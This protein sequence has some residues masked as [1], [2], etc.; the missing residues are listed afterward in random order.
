MR[1]RV[2]RAV[3][4]AGGAALLGGLVA[5]VQPVTGLG[6]VALF[7]GLVAARLER[8]ARDKGAPATMPDDSNGGG[9]GS[10]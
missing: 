7:V 8:G 3:A 5:D 10:G 4:L 2:A 9:G 6:A 1:P